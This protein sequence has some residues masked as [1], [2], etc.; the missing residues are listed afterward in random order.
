MRVLPHVV[1]AAF[2]VPSE[3]FTIRLESGADAA[4]ILAAIRDLGYEPA[5]L[6]EAP[7]KTERIQRLDDPR[8]KAVRDGLS[9]ARA[10]GVLLV[11]ELGGP[12]CRLCRLFEETTLADEGVGAAL[13]AFEFL[14]VDVEQDPAAVKDLDVHGVPDFWV[15]DGVG[16]VLARHN[17]YLDPKAFLAFL[18]LAGNR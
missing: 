12:F 8:S 15:L 5:V 10:R 17:G 1:H 14:Q 6:D 9:R 18:E 7:G 4:P 16:R 13:S 2:D 3:T 11:V